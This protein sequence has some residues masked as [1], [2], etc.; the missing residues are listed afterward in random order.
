MKM[1]ILKKVHVRNV[2]CGCS[3]SGVFSTFFFEN[4]QME[5]VELQMSFKVRMY[6]SGRMLEFSPIELLEGERKVALSIS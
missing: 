5:L 4:L 1:C 3:D 6:V 2:S